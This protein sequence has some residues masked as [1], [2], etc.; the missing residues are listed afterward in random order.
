MRVPKLI[1]FICLCT[2]LGAAQTSEKPHLNISAEALTAEQVA[3]YQLLLSD[4]LKEYEDGF[5]LANRT[6]A[7]RLGPSSSQGC[8]NGIEYPPGEGP[9]GVVHRI[10]SKLVQSFKITLVDPESQQQIIKDGD[11]QKVVLKAIEEGKKVSD[12]EVEEAVKAAFTHGM[13]WLSEIAFD[14]DHHQA[15][16]SYSFV[17]GSL[18]GDG[19]TLL[20]ESTDGK[21]KRAEVCSQW[22]S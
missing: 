5:N 1:A 21:W 4:L 8:G 20:F 16:V 22:V 19:K 3:I 17:C 12:K 9:A 13:L 10:D 11:P 7:K 14:K 2:T 6:E 15:V 18:C